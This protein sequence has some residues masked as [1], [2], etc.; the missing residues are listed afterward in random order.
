MAD[1][2]HEYWRRRLDDLARILEKH[3]FSAQVADTPAEAHEI[4][5]QRV[6]AIAPQTIAYAD[7]QTLRATRVLDTLREDTR[8]A[9]IDGFDKSKTRDENLETRRQALLSDLF[10]T[11]VNAVTQ[12]GTLVWLD[13]VGN[14]IGGVNFG[15]R[16]VILAVGRNKLTGSLEEAMSRIKTLAAP[17]NARAH[18]H[19]KTPCQ[20]TSRCHDC[21]SP[22]RICNTWLLMERCYPKGRIHIVLINEDSGY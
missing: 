11:G 15:P 2:R 17:I 4:I 7:S 13:M 14:R 1:Y 12:D 18:E 8:W 19:F 16:H 22:D 6:E 10:L 3:G 5:R 9:F 21:A 20:I